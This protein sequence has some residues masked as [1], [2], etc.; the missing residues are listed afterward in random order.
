VDPDLEAV[1]VYRLI[2]GRYE[3]SAELSSEHED[4]LST[5]LLPDLSI[6]LAAVFELP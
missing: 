4:S 2:E 5:P 1:K 6:A 3:K